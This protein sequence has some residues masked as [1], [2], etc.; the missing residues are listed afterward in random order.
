MRP[1]QSICVAGAYD[2]TA[3][4]ELSEELPPSP[5]EPLNETSSIAPF[6]LL[7]GLS[8]LFTGQCHWL[9]C[10]S[11]V[12]AGCRGRGCCWAWSNCLGPRHPEGNAARHGNGNDSTGVWPVVFVHRK[13]GGLI[14]VILQTAASNIKSHQRST[15]ATRIEEDLF[16]A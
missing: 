13:P 6:E 7:E 4:V 16:G 10:G 14:S 11:S 1:K 2:G 8:L 3:S 9:G 5:G 15:F 12:A